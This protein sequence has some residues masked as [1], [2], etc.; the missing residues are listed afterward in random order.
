MDVNCYARFPLISDT[1]K[2]I[3]KTKKRIFAMPDAAPAIPPNP[4]TPAIIAII[5]KII[6]QRNI[7]SGFSG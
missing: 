6:V 5:I 7:I 4:N 1:T 3:K 2:R